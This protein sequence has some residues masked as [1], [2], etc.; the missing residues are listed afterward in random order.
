MCC[1]PATQVVARRNTQLLLL[2]MP[3]R[4]TGCIGQASCQVLLMPSAHLSCIVRYAESDGRNSFQSTGNIGTAFQ[5]CTNCK[6]EYQNGLRYDLE[7]ARVFFVEREFKNDHMLHLRTLII[8]RVRVFHVENDSDR[9]EGDKICFKMVS[10]IDELKSDDPSKQTDWK[11]SSN[12][13]H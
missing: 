9:A 10:I 2:A 8:H 5:E 4:R 12:V 3:R 7:R 1:A 13:T 11:S 6:Q